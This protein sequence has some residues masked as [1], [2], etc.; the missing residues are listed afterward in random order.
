M[1]E[2]LPTAVFAASLLPALIENVRFTTLSNPVVIIVALAGLLMAYLTGVPGDLAPSSTAFYWIGGFLAFSA[3]GMIGVLPGGTAKFIAA[4]LPWFAPM[5]FLGVLGVSVIAIG[6]YATIVG[7]KGVAVV[8]AF[9]V[10]GL[11]AQLML[12]T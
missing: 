11:A 6:A 7:K 1:T 4:L 9:F 5:T 2:F 8:P 3:A 10:C 12:V